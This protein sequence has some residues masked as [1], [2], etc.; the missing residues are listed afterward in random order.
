MIV[1]GIQI[2]HEPSLC[3][4]KDGEVVW[5]QEERKLSKIKKIEF[6]PFRCIDLLFSGDSI[7]VDKF[8]ITGYTYSETEVGQLESYLHYKNR[9]REQNDKALE[10][11]EKQYHKRQVQKRH[12]LHQP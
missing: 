10:E 5:Y 6:A 9:H 4:I 11:E 1:C 3:L 8:V 2:H 7:N 12:N